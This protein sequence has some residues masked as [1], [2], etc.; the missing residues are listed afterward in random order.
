MNCRY[1]YEIY[2]HIFKAVYAFMG[3]ARTGSVYMTMAITLERYFSIVR[4]LASFTFKKALGPLTVAFAIAWNIP[5]FFEWKIVT[6]NL[7]GKNE[8]E[9]EIHESDFRKGIYYAVYYRMWLTFII[10]EVIPYITIIVLNATILRQIVKSYT[11]RRG[12]TEHRHYV[13]DNEENQ[14]DLILHDTR[15]TE[16][17]VGAWREVPAG[18]CGYLGDKC[19]GWGLK[20]INMHI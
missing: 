19:G 20:N 2:P 4:P 14:L 18:K 9:F 6:A 15:P 13:D 8:V 16:H 5:R 10:I 1:V 11:F 3:I 7:P 17:I 12:F